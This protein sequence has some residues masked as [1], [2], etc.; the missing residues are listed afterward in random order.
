M[1]QTT[2]CLCFKK[3][4]LSALASFS[5]KVE[6]KINKK[7]FFFLLD[8]YSKALSSL[9]RI[10]DTFDGKSFRIFS[11]E[12]VYFILLIFLNNMNCYYLVFFVIF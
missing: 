1:E 3:M 7:L 2:F 12:T 11:F 4:L 10:C 9:N 6:N 8:E 5:K